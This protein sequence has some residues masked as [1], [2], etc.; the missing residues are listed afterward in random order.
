MV[1]KRVNR[2]IRRESRGFVEFVQWRRIGKLRDI[3]TRDHAL[4]QRIDHDA[5]AF[6]GNSAIGETRSRRWRTAKDHAI[7]PV[8]D[9]RPLHFSGISTRNLIPASGSLSRC[10]AGNFGDDCAVGH[11]SSRRSRMGFSRRDGDFSHHR[12]ID[13]DVAGRSNHRARHRERH[14]VDYHHWYRRAIT[15]RARP[16]V[17]NVCPERRRGDAGQSDGARNDDFG[18]LLCYRWSHCDYARRAEE[19]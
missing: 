18:S 11:S 15:G 7:H 5:A 3:F 19:Y 13:V 9:R 8:H 17:E 1:S 14:F 2:K 16:G 4:H 10:V 12:N 6:G